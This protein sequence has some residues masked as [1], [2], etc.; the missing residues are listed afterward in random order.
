MK[1]CISIIVTF[2]MIMIIST[3]PAHADQEKSSPEDIL[4]IQTELEYVNSKCDKGKDSD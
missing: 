2:S 4:K 3:F 1:K